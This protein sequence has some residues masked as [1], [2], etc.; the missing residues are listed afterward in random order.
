MEEQGGVPLFPSLAGQS[1]SAA[2]PRGIV[3]RGAGVG[4]G[5]TAAMQGLQDL[6]QGIDP[7]QLLLGAALS[8]AF[9]PRVVG[10]AA[11][12]AG[13]AQKAMIPLRPLYSPAA[14]SAAYQVGKIPGLLD[15]ER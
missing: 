15:E 6:S 14:R 11:Y 4:A 9:S 2:T 8:P 10:E 5:V 7:T 12:R 3:A 1:L 13:Q